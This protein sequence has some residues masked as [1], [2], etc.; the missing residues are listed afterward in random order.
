MVENFNHFFTFGE[1]FVD[2]SKVSAK[3]PKL[4]EHFK[5]IGLDEV[6]VC[7][8][9]EFFAP[10]LDSYIKDDNF[11]HYHEYGLA[12]FNIGGD[13]PRFTSFAKP[14]EGNFLEFADFVFEAGKKFNVVGVGDGV[15]EGGGDAGIGFGTV[16]VKFPFETAECVICG[17][18]NNRPN[19][20]YE[21]EGDVGDEE[22][23]QN[24]AY[25]HY[26]RVHVPHDFVGNFFKAAA[27]AVDFF[28][29]SAGKIVAEKAV[30]VAMHVFKAFFGDVGHDFWLEVGVEILRAAPADYIE[31]FS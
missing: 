22:Y 23:Y 7:G 29:E 9:N 28:Y 21:S 20:H 4:V 30:G 31:N 24:C 2:T 27:E 8:V 16:D 10:K 17:Y 26:Q 1:A 19:Q 14:I 12:Q 13:A 5:E 3:H 15:G 18:E 25:F 6:K 11:E